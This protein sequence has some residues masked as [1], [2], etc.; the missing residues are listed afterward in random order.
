MISFKFQNPSTKLQI[1]TKFEISMTKTWQPVIQ[2]AGLDSIILNSVS[3]YY[4]STQFQGCE[5][6]LFGSL[7]IG[8]WVLF[9]ICY[10]VLVIF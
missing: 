6:A 1:S 7:K 2:L 4:P 9:V 3:E 5:L 8:I 10:L